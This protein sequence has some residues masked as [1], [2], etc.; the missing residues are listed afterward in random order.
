MP[1]FSFLDWPPRDSANA[2]KN[3]MEN[4]FIDYGLWS[5]EPYHQVPGR[6]RLSVR[7]R[8]SFLENERRESAL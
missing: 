6:L 3:Q 4:E 2:L 7:G 1:C 8:F 5:M